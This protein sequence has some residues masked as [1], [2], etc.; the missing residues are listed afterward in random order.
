MVSLRRDDNGNFTA[1]KRLPDDVRDEYGR[2][3]GQRFEAEFFLPA[4]KGATEAKRLFAEW[5]ADVATRISAIRLHSAEK[6]STSHAR[7]HWAS[8]VSG[9]VGCR[10]P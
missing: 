8:Q 4:T 2:R 9:I 6:G 1:R 3:Y 10:S 7:T 5:E